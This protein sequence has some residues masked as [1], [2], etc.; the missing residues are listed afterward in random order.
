MWREVLRF[1]VVLSV[2]FCALHEPVLA[3]AASEL[4]AESE[5]HTHAEPIAQAGDDENVPDPVSHEGLHHHHCPVW[6]TGLANEA[7][8]AVAQGNPA[9]RLPRAQA[10]GSRGLAPPQEPPLA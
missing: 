3:H 8:S 9:F 4:A 1:T 6:L 2:L 7:S 10:L 5:Y